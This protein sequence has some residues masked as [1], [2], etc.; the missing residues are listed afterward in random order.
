MTANSPIKKTSL[1]TWRPF[2]WNLSNLVYIVQ[3]IQRNT[4]NIHNLQNKLMV[5][6]YI[7]IK[8]LG[9]VKTTQ[10]Q[11]SSST[12]SPSFVHHLRCI[13][14]GCAPAVFCSPVPSLH[15]CSSREASNLGSGEWDPLS[16]SHTS[17][18]S[19]DSSEN[20][21]GGLNGWG[22]YYWGSLAFPL[23]AGKC[24]TKRW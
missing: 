1:S 4:S 13:C 17:H 19:R 21:M 3:G 8:K 24:Y 9:K 18:T 22:S 6:W 14:F 10:F 20:V 2:W 23:I 11:N 12:S 7:Y 16:P 15:P 5:G